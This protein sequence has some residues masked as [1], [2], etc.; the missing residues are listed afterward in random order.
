MSPP[1]FQ[2]LRP[3]GTWRTSAKVGSIR[4]S[5][6]C[7]GA[8]SPGLR[9]NSRLLLQEADED[10]MEPSC[11]WSSAGPGPSSPPPPTPALS[12]PL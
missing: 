10:L 2:I 1:F 12:F 9:P 8:H 5:G 6:G 11:E 3:L 7:G 4:G